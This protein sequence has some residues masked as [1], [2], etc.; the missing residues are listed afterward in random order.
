MA[1]FVT[2][3]TAF[4]GASTATALLTVRVEKTKTQ[5]T[6]NGVIGASP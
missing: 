1:F 6:A 2:T 3:Q 4:T 5:P